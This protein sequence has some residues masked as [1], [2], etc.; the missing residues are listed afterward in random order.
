[1]TWS[2]SVISFKGYASRL[3]D[4]DKAYEWFIDSYRPNQLPPFGVL[5]E[6]KGGKNPYFATGA[7]GTL[8]AVIMGFGGLDLD[9][10]GGVVQVKSHGL[11]KHW[12]KLTI[13]GV[14]T[15]KKTFVVTR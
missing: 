15:E 8:Q 4:T 12:K 14:G 1:M 10:E 9:P 2:L 11:P 6:C 3:G 7:G 5:A 13:T